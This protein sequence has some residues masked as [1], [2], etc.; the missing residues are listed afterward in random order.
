MSALGDLRLGGSLPLEFLAYSSRIWLLKNETSQR[1]PFSSR[2]RFGF[3]SSPDR[4][5]SS[6]GFVLYKHQGFKS[7]SKTNPNHRSRDE[8]WSRPNNKSHTA[9]VLAPLSAHG[10]GRPKLDSFGVF[11]GSP[12]Q[13]RGGPR[14]DRAAFAGFGNRR[15]MRNRPLATKPTRERLMCWFECLAQSEISMALAIIK[16]P[17]GRGFLL[18]KVY[19]A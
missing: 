1:G 19:F 14:F 2:S 3:S 8:S 18:L 13:R 12:R 16:H 7:N 15:Q 9:R 6:V 5:P 10:K 4:R 11:F 17:S